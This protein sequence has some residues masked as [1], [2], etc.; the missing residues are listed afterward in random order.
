MCLCWALPPLGIPNLYTL[1]TIILAWSNFD[2]LFLLPKGRDG[3]VFIWFL[4]LGPVP[5]HYIDL[6]LS[7]HLAFPPCWPS[8][9]DG[10]S[11]NRWGWA[12]LTGCRNPVYLLLCSLL[13]FQPVFTVC[14]R[15]FVGVIHPHL[16]NPRSSPVPFQS[17]PTA[18]QHTYPL[19]PTFSSN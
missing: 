12:H 17:F 4:A 1:L 9:G 15:V 5:M 8:P 10:Y 19:L 7:G 18:L 13:L 3:D 16:P 2:W 11:Y 6:G 14:M